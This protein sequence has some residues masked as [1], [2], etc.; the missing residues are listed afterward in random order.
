LILVLALAAISGY[1]YHSTSYKYG[2]DVQGGMRLTYRVKVAPKDGKAVDPTQF[3]II[4]ERLITVLEKRISGPIGVAE[5]S[6][7][8]KGDDEVAIELPGFTDPDKARNVL[9]STASIKVYW[10]KNVK[11]AKASYRKYDVGSK[12]TGDKPVVEFTDG[13]R[14]LTPADEMLKDETQDQFAAYRSYRNLPLAERTLDKAYQALTK[15]TSAA[16]AEY[17]DW[18]TKFKWDDRAAAWDGYQ[19][20]I[21]GWE[22]LLEGDD[23]KNAEPLITGNSVKP[24][25]EFQGEGAKKLETWCKQH[26][27]DE[28]NIAFVLDGVVLNIA[29]LQKGAVLSDRGE[30]NGE[31]TQEYVNSLCALLRG[32]ALPA[33]L[34]ETSMQTLDPVIGKVAMTQMVNAGLISVG[35]IALFLLAYYVF[36][37]F[38]ALIALGLYVLFNLAILKLTG[39]TF[40]LAA[41]AGFILSIGMAVDANILVFERSKEEMREGRSLLTAVELGFKRAFPSILDSNVCT[42]ITSFVLFYLGTGPVKGFATTLIIGVMIS[43]FTA[44]T[45]TRSL[46]I[47]AVSSGI[48]KN[49]KVFALERQWFGKELG[50]VMEKS[51]LWFAISIATIIPGLIFIAMGGIRP[52]VEFRGG[53]EATYVVPKGSNLDPGKVADNLERGGFPGSNVKFSDVGGQ[54]LA[55]VTAPDVKLTQNTEY[56]AIQKGTG[57]LEALQSRP[58]SKVGGSIKAETVNNAILSVIVSSALIILYL[59][60]RFG[61]SV[62]GFASGL[63]F[64]ASA[65]GALAHDILL[66]VGVAAIVG[67]LAGWEISSLSITAMLTMI[68]FS[69][70]DTVVIFDRVR[71]NLRKPHPGEEFGHLCNRSVTQSFARSLNTSMTVIVTLLILTIFGTPTIDLKFFCLAMLVGII[72][73]T[74]SSIFNATPI[75]YLWDKATVKKQGPEKGLMGLATAEMNRLRALAAQTSVG[76]PTVSAPTPGGGPAPDR[77]YGKTKRVDPIKASERNIDEE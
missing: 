7:V 38:V 10:A 75:L 57:G 56:E 67:K 2:L 64:G 34:E 69:V 23:L 46:L 51:K 13:T 74:Y 61:S 77:R 42:I 65:I 39:A 62:G 50:H 44:V 32:G 45:V 60:F 8:P 58:L 21:A 54:K 70:H 28:D 1:I 27:Y 6:I 33:S 63:K 53:Y 72:S 16:P 4:R 55:Y 26:T 22:I 76:A 48:V 68:G 14:T 47:F 18:K 59:A 37:G 24:T 43:L 49:E 12:K 29:P 15:T 40:S 36:P 3:Q 19:E 25:F 71:E 17:T 9:S 30:I 35:F 66:V 41:M 52:N 31:F 73:G 20:M 5:G 11:S